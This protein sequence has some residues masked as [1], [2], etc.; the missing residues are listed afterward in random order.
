MAVTLA[1]TCAAW[2]AV[3]SLATAQAPGNDNYLGSTA[4]NSFGSPLPTVNTRTGTIVNATVQP[5]DILEGGAGGPI[6]E[7]LG[8]QRG[9]QVVSFGDTVWWDFY[10]HRPGFVRAVVETDAFTPVVGAMP[11]VR[12]GAVPNIGQFRCVVGGLGNATLDYEFKV[13]EGGAYTIQIGAQDGLG[14]EGP[15]TLTL[16]YDPDT[17]RD[18]FADSLDSCPSNGGPNLIGGCPDGD[19]DGVIDRNDRCQGPKGTPAHQGCLDR[20]RDGRI[21]PDDKCP[22]ETTRGSRDRNDNGC[23]DR[24]LLKPET[25]LTS[26]LYC[27]GTVCHGIRVKRLAVSSLPR[28]TRVTVSCT[29]HGCK[30]A[31]KKVGKKHR[32][33][34]FSGKALK[35]GVGLSI[36]VARKGYVGRH[37]TYWI[38]PNDWKKTRLSC[39]KSGKPVR[40]T[41]QLQVR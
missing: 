4:I 18:G 21:D 31:S 9:N 34:F 17:D 35:A 3:P 6:A 33:S 30:K 29:K 39:L 26:G 23:P 11:F 10:P 38:Q 2:L 22:R 5:A 32:V 12:D 14:V 19:G 8:C 25:K 37:V 24:E 36:D 13:Q 20:D 7:N 41:R 15:Y 1:C 28:G 27:T 40:C 16:Y